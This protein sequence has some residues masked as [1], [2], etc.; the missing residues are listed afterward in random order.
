MYDW[1]ARTGLPA[2]GAE[3]TGLPITRKAGQGHW[4]GRQAERWRRHQGARG[5]A[6]VRGRSR[7]A[8]RMEG[9]GL[10]GGIARVL[11][12]RAVGRLCTL[13]H[14]ITNL[15]HI[16]T[17]ISTLV[18]CHMIPSVLD[19]FHLASVASSFTLLMRC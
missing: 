9:G 19:S 16:S 10:L 11:W 8:G 1:H 3:V 4:G 17:F 2:R 7:K 6:A 12:R 18:I 14:A 5:A 13:P 15:L